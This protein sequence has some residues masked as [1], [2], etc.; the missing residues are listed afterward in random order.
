[1]NLQAGLIQAVADVIS[2]FLPQP[3]GVAHPY[4]YWIPG[5]AVSLGYGWPSGHE[6]AIRAGGGLSFGYDLGAWQG[7]E[8]MPNL[9]LEYAW[10]KP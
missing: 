8:V 9:A 7:P 5:L 4:A 2:P 10:R 1:M 6:V 3:Q